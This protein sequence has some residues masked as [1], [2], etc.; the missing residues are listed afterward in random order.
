MELDGKKIVIIGGSSG[1]GLAAARMALAEKASVTICSRSEVKLKKAGE[2]LGDPVSTHVVD[3]SKEDDLKRLFEN[4]LEL[5]HL[6]ITAGYTGGGGLIVKTDMAQVRMTMDTRFWGC[7]NATHFAAGR[8]NKD[9]SV[10]IMS[11]NVAQRPIRGSSV[12]AAAVAAV[13]SFARAAALE[14]API[15]VNAIRAG[16]VDT[17]LLDRFGENRQGI[18]DGYIKRS[19]LKRVGRP[20]D[21]AAAAIYLMKNEFTTGTV[22]PIDGG[23]ILV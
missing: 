21:V 6:F 1:I 23:G 3:L 12:G 11:G 8:I 17:P 5:D 20:E 2:G 13:E 4:I 18:I 9:G 7:Y 22:L 19:P 15:R 14:L 10:T 16:L